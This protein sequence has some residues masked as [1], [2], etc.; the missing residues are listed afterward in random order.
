[1]KCNQHSFTDASSQRESEGRCSGH[2]GWR[3]T[4][5]SLYKGLV[6]DT[7]KN[8]KH[9]RKTKHTHHPVDDAK[10]IAEALLAMKEELGLRI[11]FQ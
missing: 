3:G 1:M 10:G 11:K 9:L 6:K 5:G 8:F 7:W 2:S 4:L